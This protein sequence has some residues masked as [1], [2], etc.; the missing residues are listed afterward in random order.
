MRRRNRRI[1]LYQCQ[2]DRPGFKRCQTGD[3]APANRCAVFLSHSGA[4]LTLCRAVSS[5]LVRG[6]DE[7][8]AGIYLK[9]LLL[10]SL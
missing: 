3:Y 5:A 6:A 9:L 4:A 1:L 10:F 2:M 7:S 8:I